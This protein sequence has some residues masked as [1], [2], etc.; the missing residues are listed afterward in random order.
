MV[1]Q[2]SKLEPGLVKFNGMVEV[3][4]DKKNMQFVVVKD[5]SGKIQL[6]VDKVGFML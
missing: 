6:F 5:F 1:S 2:I 3:V 4:R